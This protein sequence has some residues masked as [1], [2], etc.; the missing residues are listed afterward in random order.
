MFLHKLDH[1]RYWSLARWHVL[2]PTLSTKLKAFHPGYIDLSINS[3][4]PEPNSNVRA[5]LKNHARLLA[6]RFTMSR[7]IASSS[8][9]SLVCT[10]RP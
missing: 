6:K 8:S 2:P 4:T 9:V 5:C 10:W 1:I 3:C 7:I